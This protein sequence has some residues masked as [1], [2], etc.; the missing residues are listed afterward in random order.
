MT[1]VIAAPS[2]RNPGRTSDV[3]SPAELNADEPA[4]HADE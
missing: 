2:T 3:A 1:I 4:L